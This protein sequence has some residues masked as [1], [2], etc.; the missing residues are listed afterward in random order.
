MGVDL[1]WGDDRREQ[2][3]VA[4]E[5]EAPLGVVGLGSD[6][7]DIGGVTGVVGIFLG[8][9]EHGSDGGS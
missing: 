4:V 1:G 5:V 7:F 6:I 8:V 9:K 3:E 2:G